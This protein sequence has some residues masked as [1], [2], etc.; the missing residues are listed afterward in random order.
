MDT[1]TPA[2]TIHPGEILRDELQARHITQKKFAV[3]INVSY[4]MLNEIINGKRPISANIAL[5]LE[6][7]LGI[8]A[9]IWV[10]LQSEYNLQ[11]ACLDKGIVAKLENIRKICAS[12]L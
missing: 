5:M 11:T 4:T 10:N 9:Y 6:A 3:I 8:K 1:L 7:A 2:I 12:V